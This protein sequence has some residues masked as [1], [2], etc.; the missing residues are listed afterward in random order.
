[1]KS[2]EVKKGMGMGLLIVALLVVAL[3]M[4]SGPGVSDANAVSFQ[5]S[6]VLNVDYCSNGGCLNGL[7]GGTV[8]LAQDGTDRVLVTVALNPALDLFH[9]TVAFSSFV[10]NLANTSRT[11]VT[12][13]SDASFTVFNTEA[14]NIHNDG[15]GFWRYGLDQTGANFSGVSSLSFDVTATGLTTD[16]FHNANDKGNYFAASVYN[17]N[18]TTCTG[19]I[20]AN[21][22]STAVDGSTGPS[23]GAGS[24]GGSPVPEPA[25]LLLLGSGLAGLG[26]WGWKRRR[27]DVQA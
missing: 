4:P 12:N 21:G 18:D 11:R 3:V 16:S 9:N 8:T 14:G 13:I 26:L 6:Y 1:M 23:A 19:V 15:S 25:S 20:A 2:K 22:G 7:V 17:L 5:T 27:E 10:Y 24:C